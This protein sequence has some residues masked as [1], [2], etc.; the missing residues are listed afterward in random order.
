M[1]YPTRSLSTHMRAQSGIGA[2][3]GQ[4]SALSARIE[5]K[6]AELEHLKELKDLSGA[7]AS[8]ME[9]LEQ[10]LSTL[11]DGTEA[12]AAVIG[13]WHNVLGAINMASTKLAKPASAPVNED[14]PED[15]GPLPETLVRIPTEH[16]PTLHAQTEN[17]EAAAA[18][19]ASMASP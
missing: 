10:K 14:E 18:E 19:D 3:S 2:P 6:R 7:V 15:D 5:E 4:Q 17:M 12:I 13:N 16:A 1:S 11:T 8:Q 9:A